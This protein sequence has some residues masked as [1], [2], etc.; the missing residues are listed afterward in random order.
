ME[1]SFCGIGRCR[2]E[3]PIA[4]AGCKN[5]ARYG[6]SFAL[7]DRSPELGQRSVLHGSGACGLQGLVG[8][9][10]RFGRPFKFH[11]IRFLLSLC[12][13][14]GCSLLCP[15][16][17]AVV[18]SVR[19]LE[20]A[21]PEVSGL[22]EAFSQCLRAAWSKEAWLCGSRGFSQGFGFGGA[23]GL[24]WLCRRGFLWRCRQ[25]GE[26]SGQ[27]AKEEQQR[28]LLRSRPTGWCVRG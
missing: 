11:P 26:L 23:A 2:Q 24:N 9:G 17:V 1:A 6:G 22:G 8:I 13:A 10:P 14:A 12:F 5:C 20:G 28:A 27:T 21:A 7:S 18:H 15:S 4:E 19:L 16:A 3:A 25:M